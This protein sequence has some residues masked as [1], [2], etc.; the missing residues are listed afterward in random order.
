MLAV[1]EHARDWTT[2]AELADQVG[3][4]PRSIRSYVGELKEASAPLEI[5][6]SSSS[7]YRLHH[8]AY[9]EFLERERVTDGGAMTPAERLSQLLR[10][11]LDESRPLDVYAE[12]DAAFLSESTIESDLTRARTRLGGSGLTIVRRGSEISLEGGELDRR[13]L[14]SQLYR[15]D[16]ERGL[17]VLTRVQQE[18]GLSGLTEF[19]SELLAALDARGYFVNEYGINDVLLHVAI[20]LDRVRRGRHLTSPTTPV[21]EAVA[22]TVATLASVIPRHFRASL[23][24]AELQYLAI[25]LAT[26]VV[27]PG[28]EDGGEEIEDYLSPDVVETVRGIVDD[29]SDEYL[30]DLRDSAFTIRLALHVQN[31]LTRAGENT[32]SRNPLTRSIKTS[33][34]LIYELAVYIASR[35][36]RAAGIVVTDD[37]IAYIAMHVGAYLEQQSGRADAVTCTLVCPGYYDMHRLLRDRILRVFGQDLEVTTVITDT[38]TDWSRSDTGLVLTTIPPAAP[39]EN[40]LVIQPFL[41]DGDVERVRGAIARVRRARRRGAIK[42]ELLRFFDASRFLRN[43]YASDE[44]AMIRALGARMISAGLI[45]EVYL[46]GAVERERMSSTAFTDSLAVPHAMAMTANE[47]AIAIVLN[48]RAMDWGGSR[49]NVIAF[50][51]FNAEERHSFQAV[52]DQFVE[53]FSDRDAVGQLIARSADFPSFIDELVRMIDS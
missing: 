26:R 19:K 5:I 18:F 8:D 12:A 34:P 11:L 53:V 32:Y 13:R 15:E 20:A 47:T 40:I 48:D 33:Y 36:Q 3:V 22:R 6:E 25:L 35:L 30:V 52:F 41:T 46:D 14:L 51:A 29:A 31:L 17:I 27:T 28:K 21:G 44:I 43:F 42:R 39:R 4:T 2:A 37:E 16:A 10:R 38:D 7:G 1:L 24:E 45:D 50:V 9:A 23:D 49:V